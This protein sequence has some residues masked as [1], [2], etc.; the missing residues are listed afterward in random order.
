MEWRF[1][2]T[3]RRSATMMW[4]YNM[5]GWLWM[6]PV[7]IIFWGV[8]IGGIVLVI[9]AVSMPRS[10]RETPMD[11]LRRRLASGQITRDEYEQTRKLL[12]G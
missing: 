2:G 12:E 3:A 7:M 11:A 1:D 8:V 5:V 4:G 10:D 6:L 9:R